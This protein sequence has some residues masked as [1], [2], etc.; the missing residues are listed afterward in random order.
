MGSY[1]RLPFSWLFRM[2]NRDM[3]EDGDGEE[4]AAA[5]ERPV[6]ASMALGLCCDLAM[7]YLRKESIP[8]SLQRYLIYGTSYLDQYWVNIVDENTTFLKFEIYDMLCIRK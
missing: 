5:T 6:P 3:R 1:A 2:N 7:K 4:T 8:A